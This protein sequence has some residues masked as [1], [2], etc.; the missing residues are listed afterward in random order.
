MDGFFCLHRV[1]EIQ[2]ITAMI[3]LSGCQPQ[4]KGVKL[5]IVPYQSGLYGTIGQIPLR[6]LLKVRLHPSSSDLRRVMASVSFCTDGKTSVLV[7]SRRAVGLL[8]L[9]SKQE[10]G[11]IVQNNGALFC[12]KGASG[13]K[14]R[15]RR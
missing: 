8:L 9:S 14:V 3:R 13:R 2:I 6:S 4:W 5:S 11:R 15:R 10:E 1:S 7:A 12:G